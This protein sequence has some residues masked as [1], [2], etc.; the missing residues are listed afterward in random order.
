M[1]SCCLLPADAFLLVS[2]GTYQPVPAA[3]TCPV[4][5]AGSAHNLT[6]Q[7]ECEPCTPGFYQ[8]GLGGTSCPACA[9]GAFS[10]TYSAVE[11]TDCAAV[12]GA[13][14]DTTQVEAS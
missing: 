7:V 14:E 2:P 12:S 5:L 10:V 13:E 4:C 8:D 1:L 9:E 3:V 11:C 6:G